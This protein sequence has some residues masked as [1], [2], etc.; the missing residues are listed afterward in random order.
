MTPKALGKASEEEQ[1]GPFQLGPQALTLPPPPSLLHGPTSTLVGLTLTTTVGTNFLVCQARNPVSF[2]VP[3]T[4]P[5][6]HHSARVLCLSFPAK[7]L[8]VTPSLFLPNSPKVRIK[9]IVVSPLKK[10]SLLLGLLFNC[11][12]NRPQQPLEKLLPPP[13]GRKY[14]WLRK[15]S[16]LGSLNPMAGS[17]LCQESLA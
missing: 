14:L 6:P 12:K 13:P 7:K 11:F 10:Y 4:A 17:L 16:A 15:G 2:S 5:Q 1:K 9:I 3:D 8:K